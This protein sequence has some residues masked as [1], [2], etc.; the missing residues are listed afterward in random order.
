MTIARFAIT[1]TAKDERDMLRLALPYD[2]AQG[3]TF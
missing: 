3:S 2:R 1:S